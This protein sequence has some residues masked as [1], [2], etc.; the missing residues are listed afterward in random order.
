[1]KEVYLSSTDGKHQ[2]HISIWEPDVPAIGIVQISHGMLEYINRYD[3]FA[4]YL[5]SIP[6]L[7][8]NN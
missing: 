5:V 8:T 7:I 3:P 1:M 2:L 4:K 6:L